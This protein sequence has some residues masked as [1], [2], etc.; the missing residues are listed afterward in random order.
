[1]IGPLPSG[2]TLVE[3]RGSVI[4][5]RKLNGAWVVSEWDGTDWVRTHSFCL[6]CPGS[7]AKARKEFL[8]R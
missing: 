8:C 2:W 4:L 7:E 1:M 5:A 6:G 3:S